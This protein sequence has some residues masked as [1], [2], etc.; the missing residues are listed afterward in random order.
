MNHYN[1]YFGSFK[2]SEDLE[3][4]V[5]CDPCDLH[6]KKVVRDCRYTTLNTAVQAKAKGVTLMLNVALCKN[7]RKFI[8]EMPDISTQA[9]S[10][11]TSTQ[12]SENGN[13][14]QQLSGASSHALGL[15]PAVILEE[16][17]YQLA[18]MGS[19][20]I[21][22]AS[23]SQS[24]KIQ[25]AKEKLE[26]VCHVLIKSM[27]RAINIEE[28]SVTSRRR[29]E[30]QMA[31]EYD[32]LMLEVKE[33]L[34]TA[35]RKTSQQLLTIGPTSWTPYYAAKFFHVSR[36]LVEKSRELREKHGI[37]STP[38]YAPK[39]SI[40][41]EM[42]KIVE[43]F[44]CD[45]MYS[46][47]MPGKKDYVSLGHG[48]HMQKRLILCNLRELYTEFKKK[49]PETAKK[50]GKPTFISLRP[51]WCVVAGSAGTHNVCVCETHQ[52]AKLLLRALG[53]SPSIR[54]IIPLAVCAQSNRECKLSVCQLPLCR[55]YITEH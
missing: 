23:L 22:V 35:N 29:I 42:K 46:R 40:T 24:H 37:C 41:D 3:I 19:S 33:K 36:Q 38:S 39:S 26:E 48:Q 32:K 2:E 49:H 44:Y 28:S 25:Y 20:A 51:K 5:C 53:L 7:C 52:N 14:S 11:P 18:Q 27:C 47:M 31:S 15:S 1:F 21:D 4:D 45:D 16:L 17:N 9:E 13:T 34:L 30:Q 12:S 10:E 55:R 8:H 50:V 54:D 43:D 6:F